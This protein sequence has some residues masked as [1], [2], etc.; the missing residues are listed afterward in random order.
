MFFISFQKIF[1]RFPHLRV[2]FLSIFLFKKPYTP[3]YLLCCKKADVLSNAS[4][5]AVILVA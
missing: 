1:T 3:A 5:K 4:D 2:F